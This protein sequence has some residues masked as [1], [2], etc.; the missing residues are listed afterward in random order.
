M[1]M[2]NLQGQL[3][4]SIQSL[5]QDAIKLRFKD[6]SMFRTPEALIIYEQH[7]MNEEELMK[8]LENVVYKEKLQTPKIGM[9]NKDIIYHFEDKKCIP[10]TY[11]LT[12]KLVQVGVLPE[13]KDMYIEEYKHTKIE[14][15]LVPLHWYIDNYTK[16]Y[17]VPDFIFP[18][19]E[20]DLFDLIVAEAVQRKAMDITISNQ[21]DKGTIYYNVK[22]RKVYANRAIEPEN[23]TELANYLTTLAGS[24]QTGEK[25]PKHFGVKLDSHHRGRCEL[26][27]TIY[28]KSITIRVLSNDFMNKTLE[29]L[30]LDDETIFLLRNEMLNIAP[31]IRL[32]VGPTAS[33]KNTTML[34]GIN[35][36][37]I[38]DIYKAISIE[39]PV[40][41]YVKNME[42]IEAEDEEEFALSVA[43]SIRQNPDLVYASEITDWTAKEIMKLANTG[44]AVFSTLHCNDSASSIARLV[45]ITQFHPDRI[46]K[47]MHSVIYQKLVRIG[48]D[49]FPYNTSIRFT[50][51]LK[52]ELLGKSLGEITMILSDIEDKQI[53]RKRKKG[54]WIDEY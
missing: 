54:T 8:Y 50:K 26:V 52:R 15:I 2:E 34:A 39:S 47:D 24:P 28:G 46:I 30:N 45:D 17:G 19:P 5:I 41:I 38:P 12:A 6:P 42:Q 48:D 21:P 37:L 20:K 40:E 27:N 13:N 22:K 16:M 29:S 10:I 11:S 33:G 35:E 9:I 49:I 44:K 1:S 32:V 23:V 4:A 18:L 51:E 43:S 36:I 14:K 7:L 31:G 3:P 53:N 25:K